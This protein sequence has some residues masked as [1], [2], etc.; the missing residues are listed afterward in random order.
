MLIG[1][2]GANAELEE[3]AS[4]KDSCP[5]TV[6]ASRRKKFTKAAGALRLQVLQVDVLCLYMLSFLHH[7]RQ[8]KSK[9]A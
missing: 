7:L 8:T 5:G 2:V 1:C 6:L 9:Q 3:A 4:F